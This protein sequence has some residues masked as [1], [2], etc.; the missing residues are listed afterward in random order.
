MSEQRQQDHCLRCTRPFIAPAQVKGYKKFC[1]DKCRSE[2]HSELRKKAL[3]LM[4]SSG[5]GRD[6]NDESGHD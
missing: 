3:E 1:S 6:E 4:R 5:S 2:W